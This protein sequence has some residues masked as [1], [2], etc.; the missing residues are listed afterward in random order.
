M[1]RN[2]RSSRSSTTGEVKADVITTPSIPFRGAFHRKTFPEIK[3]HQRS[4][5]T[6][7]DG[8]SVIVVARKAYYDARVC[9]AFASS[10]FEPRFNGR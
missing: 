7:T 5:H 1:E 4:A 9:G 10:Q 6:H 2:I 3:H 8:D